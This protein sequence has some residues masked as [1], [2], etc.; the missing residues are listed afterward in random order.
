MD[1]YTDTITGTLIN[2]SPP[3]IVTD[4]VDSKQLTHL[5]KLDPPKRLCQDVCKLPVSA[6]MIHLCNSIRHTLPDVMVASVNVFTPFMVYWI[7]A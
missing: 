6:D 5:Q 2:I 7:F 3:L 4:V 1:T